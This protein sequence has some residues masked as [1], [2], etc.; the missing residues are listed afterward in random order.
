MSQNNRPT[1]RIE[2]V[3]P[4]WISLSSDGWTL[5]ITRNEK[6]SLYWSR[7]RSPSGQWKNSE[8]EKGEVEK[9][10]AEFISQRLRLSDFWNAQTM[11]PISAR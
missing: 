10:V 9:I 2:R 5:E 4:T 3:T 1:V 7:L 6:G 8:V 11:L